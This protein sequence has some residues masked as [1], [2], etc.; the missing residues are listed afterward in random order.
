LN[1]HRIRLP[2]TGIKG[3][4]TR[5]IG[6]PERELGHR[7]SCTYKTAYH[8]LT[9]SLLGAGN[10]EVRLPTNDISLDIETTAGDLSVDQARIDLLGDYRVQSVAKEECVISTGGIR[11]R[12]RVTEG[13]LDGIIRE[14]DI[15]AFDISLRANWNFYGKYHLRIRVEQAH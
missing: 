6:A 10:N 1:R 13:A 11:F 9:L 5:L 14:G 8:T 2:V 15:L 7:Q 4:N 3:Q 12:L